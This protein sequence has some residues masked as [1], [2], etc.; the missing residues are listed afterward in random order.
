MARHRQCENVNWV[1]PGEIKALEEDK[2]F[3]LRYTILFTSTVYVL[4]ADFFAL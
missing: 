4:F 1:I 3:Y 2:F